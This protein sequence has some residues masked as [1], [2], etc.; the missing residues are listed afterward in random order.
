MYFYLRYLR[1]LL[2]ALRGVTREELANSITHGLGILL[3]LIGLP[4]LAAHSWMHN[5]IVHTGA[6]IVFGFSLLSVYVSSTLHHIA[7]HARLKRIALTL[8]HAC[9]YVLIAGTY[10]PFLV[11]TMRGM[12]GGLLLAAIWTMGLAGILWKV[13]FRTPRSWRHELVSV[14]FYLLMGWLIL[15]VLE[16]F[17][18]SVALPGILLLLAGGLCYSF[19]VVFFLIGHVAYAHAVWHLFVLTGSVL[20]YFSV[21]WYAV[22][23]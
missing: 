4:V 13:L 15:L 21:L 8:D 11:S 22:P 5:N 16:P 9:I 19:G 23:S 17:V 14:G 18:A 3:T 6:V 7:T 2:D 12:A 10:T 20:H 1:R